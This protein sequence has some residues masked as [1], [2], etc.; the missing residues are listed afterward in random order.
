MT[1]NNS[2]VRNEGVVRVVLV[3]DYMLVSCPDMKSP[4]GAA[5]MRLAGYEVG[6]WEQDGRL[7]YR[8]FGLHI[9][10]SAET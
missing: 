4:V 7:K 10:A 6:A 5:R 8:D 1:A 2:T 9:A 3:C